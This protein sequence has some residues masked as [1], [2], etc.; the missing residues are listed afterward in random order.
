M[1]NIIIERIYHYH[2]D[3]G[4]SF[5]G[6]RHATYEINIVLDGKLDVTCSNKVF[7]IG[8]GEAI[9]FDGKDFHRNS[10]FSAEKAD[11]FSVSF[12]ADEFDVDLPS[13]FSLNK[14]D[15]GLL[16]VLDEEIKE[17]DDNNIPLHTYAADLIFGALLCR[18]KPCSIGLDH[19]HTTLSDI[20]RDAVLFMRDNLDK[21]LKVP[22]MAK[23]IGACLTL[24]KKAFSQYAG[25][26]VREY[27]IEMKIDHAK[28]CLLN[29]TPSNTI[30]AELA[31]SSPAYFSQTFKR[32]C[33]I[34]PREYLVQQGKTP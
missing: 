24:L 32:I 21:D 13:S 1:K 14:R 15:F 26:G 11:F 18:L 27:F 19:K 25:K 6:H 8:S 28:K 7:C 3:H 4:Y 34:S 17:V 33:G 10:V 9:L 31:F 23:E 29:G 16:E 20:Y 22:D 2:K 5:S 30:A 12:S